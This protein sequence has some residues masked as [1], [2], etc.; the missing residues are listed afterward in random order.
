[1]N[2]EA[3]DRRLLWHHVA[4]SSATCSDLPTITSAFTLA[5]TRSDTLDSQ[6]N[7]VVWVGP[8]GADKYNVVC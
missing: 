7:W 8:V 5:P 6:W 1:M 2:F 4:T 3:A